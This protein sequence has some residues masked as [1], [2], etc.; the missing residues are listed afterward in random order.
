MIFMNHMFTTQCCSGQ[1]ALRLYVD[2]QSCASVIASRTH[3]PHTNK[4]H[5][6]FISGRTFRC[7]ACDTAA[8]GV[9]DQPVRFICFP[10]SVHRFQML[11]AAATATASREYLER[12]GEED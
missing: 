1:R 10:S 8:A 4:R 11:D 2:S 9:F 12:G 6:F 7:C 5:S 3:T